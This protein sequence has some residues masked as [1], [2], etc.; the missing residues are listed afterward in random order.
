MMA[1]REGWEEVLDLMA[2]SES[3]GAFGKRWK[4]ARRWTGETAA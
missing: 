2:L 4:P 1:S 3:A